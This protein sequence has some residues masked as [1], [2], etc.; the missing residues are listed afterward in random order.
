M[1]LLFINTEIIYKFF[2]QINIFKICH[3]ISSVLLKIYLPD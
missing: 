3:M 2:L 1:D